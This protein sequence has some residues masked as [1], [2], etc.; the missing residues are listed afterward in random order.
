MKL[1]ARWV[2][3]ANRKGPKERD[4]GGGRTDRERGRERKDE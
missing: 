3:A 2:S 1:S 4:E